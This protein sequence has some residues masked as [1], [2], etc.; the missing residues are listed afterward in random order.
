MSFVI[1]TEARSYGKSYAIEPGG[2]GINGDCGL[3]RDDSKA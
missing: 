3:G 2:T 1:L